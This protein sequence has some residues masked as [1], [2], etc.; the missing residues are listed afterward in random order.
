M[1]DVRGA[2]NGQS[3]CIQEAVVVELKGMPL[4]NVIP[5]EGRRPTNRNGQYTDKNPS[6]L[7]ILEEM[8][9]RHR[10]I[11]DT[12]ETAAVRSAYLSATLVPPPPPTVFGQ[13]G[14]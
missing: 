1:K 12:R 11:L 3:D 7:T 10:T 8:M 5:G 13:C 9:K 14:D 6:S 2:R 4:E